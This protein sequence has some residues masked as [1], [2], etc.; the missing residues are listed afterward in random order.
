[1]KHII[2]V[3]FL[4]KFIT[5]YANAEDST[6][7]IPDSMAFIPGGTYI[8]LY[9]GNKPPVKV[10]PF[11]MDEHPV[12]N[13]EFLD[14]V[15][16]NPE[17]R[18][19]NVKK[20]FADENYLKHWKDDFNTDDKLSH[21]NS[22]VTNVSWFAGKAYCESNGKRLPTAN[23]WEYAAMANEKSP[24]GSDDSSYHQRILDWYS[25][26]T[27]SLIPPVGS[28]FKNHYGVYDL[29]G[30]VW[31]WV[32][33]FNSFLLTGESR[34]DMGLDRELFCAKSASGS[35]D[36]KNYAAFMRYAFRTSLKA[37]FTVPNLGF[38]CVKGLDR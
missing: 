16:Q 37:N 12:T 18:K 1:M 28:T 32:L 38:R 13:A 29:H 25:K 5:G 19:S 21:V 24:D 27:P 2:L 7:K 10:E 3:L 36:V 4:S 17:W 11:F 20:V 8:P 14:F 26:P 23:E 9:A 15:K 34:G 6:D 30:L 22:P 31:E 35:T 33:D